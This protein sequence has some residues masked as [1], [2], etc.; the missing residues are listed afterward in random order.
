MHITQVGP[1]NGVHQDPV[2]DLLCQL[3]QA[4]ASLGEEARMQA[5]RE[6][7]PFHRE[8]T[9]SIDAVLSRFRIIG[10]RAAMGNA[11]IQMSW[12]GYTWIL[13]RAIGVPASDLINVLQ[14]VQGQLPH[15]SLIREL[16]TR[17][18][19]EQVALYTATSVG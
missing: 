7:M 16:L 6:L 8:P 1:V 4:F 2:N 12:E 18:Q 15:T 5:M 19:A 13:L 9:E 10:W 17:W 3:A 14:P 11:G